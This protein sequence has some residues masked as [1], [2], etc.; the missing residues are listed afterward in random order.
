MRTYGRSTV[1]RDM[2]SAACLLGN[3]TS[4]EIE[5]QNKNFAKVSFIVVF[6][7]LKEE[8]RNES[9]EREEPLSDIR[10]V[11]LGRQWPTVLMRD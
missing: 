2:C 8:T 9:V 3:Q 6:E 7:Y 1:D 10:R 11:E 4:V 5:K